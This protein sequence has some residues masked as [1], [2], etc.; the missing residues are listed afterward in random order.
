MKRATFAL[1]LFA[2]PGSRITGFTPVEDLT[3]V[4]QNRLW[5]TNRTRCAMTADILRLNDAEADAIS[6]EA[7]NPI[8]V[9]ELT[10]MRD[11]ALRSASQPPVLHR[12]PIDIFPKWLQAYCHEVAASIEVPVD[13]VGFVLLGMPSAAYGTHLRVKP[14]PGFEK[15]CHDFFFLIAPVSLGKSPIFSHLQAPLADA[16]LAAR[17]L[18]PIAG[19]VINRVWGFPASRLDVLRC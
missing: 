11:R 14:K 15:C 10:A 12:F 8:S 1:R 19:L 13:P 16:L 17:E 4:R 9:E 2:S 6:D 18:L 7:M 3:R 5:F